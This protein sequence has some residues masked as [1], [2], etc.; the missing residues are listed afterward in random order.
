MGFRFQRRIQ[1]LPGVRLNFSKS[2]ISTSVGTKGAWVTFSKKGTRT[3]L[4]LPGSGFSYTEYQSKKHNKYITCPSCHKKWKYHPSLRNK[5]L[6][7]TCKHRFYLNNPNVTCEN[8][9]GCGISGIIIFCLIIGLLT[10]CISGIK[11]CMDED[12]ARQRF[13]QAKNY[14][15]ARCKEEVKR[16]IIKKYPEKYNAYIGTI[17]KVSII[18]IQFDS[19]KYYWICKGEFTAERER[20]KTQYYCSDTGTFYVELN[21]FLSKRGYRESPEDVKV[22]LNF[23]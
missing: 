9:Q 10:F 4:G 7:C 8:K 2:G 12:S 5:E 1:I 16:A 18:D 19:H 23:N 22:I 17:I 21:E 15:Y 6:I 3:T 11:S 14:A 20:S 13:E